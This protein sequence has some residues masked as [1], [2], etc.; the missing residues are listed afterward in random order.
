MNNQTH[1]SVFPNPAYDV[2]HIT[3]RDPIAVQVTIFT[4]AGQAVWAGEIMEFTDISVTG[5]ARGVYYLQIKAANS[6]IEI[7]KLVLE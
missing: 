1:I 4:T 6:A 3:S 5:W 7:Q 2:L